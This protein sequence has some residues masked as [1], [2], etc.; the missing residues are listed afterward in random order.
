MN[1]VLP[2]LSLIISVVIGI[3]YFSQKPKVVYIDTGK[4]FA[5]F[6]LSKE[7][8]VKLQSSQKSKKAAIDSLTE[9]LSKM[10]TELQLN[11]KNK[12][13]FSIATKLD[14]EIYYKKQMFEEENQ[15]EMSDLM[16]TIWTRL[17]E[18]LADFGKEYKYDFV[19]GANGQ[20][21]ILYGADQLDVTK[22]AIEFANKK[23]NGK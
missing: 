8:D 14:E 12:E 4:L 21:N 1:K 6:K 9:S 20:A 13:L 16:K 17:N 18:Y 7:L 23:Y 19:M 11:P 2:V 10:N 5:E 22:E 3:V 15:K